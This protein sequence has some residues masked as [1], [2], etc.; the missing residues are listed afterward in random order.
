MSYVFDYLQGRGAVFT[1]IPHPDAE[2][3]AGAHALPFS[4]EEVVKTVVVMADFGPALMVVPASRRLDLELAGEATADP[5]VRPATE[6]ELEHA[7]PDYQIGA[8]PPLSMLLLAPMFVDPAVAERETIVF[9]AGRQ[10]VS[11]RMATRDLFGTDPVV[12]TPLTADTR[13]TPVP[14][15]EG[16]AGRLTSDGAS[17]VDLP[18]IA[19]RLASLQTS[20]DPARPTP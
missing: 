11:I 6:R 20:R 3:A 13:V 16:S 17:V 10:D 18:S 2:T 15:A 19:A 5:A 7:F 14:D 1:V 8:L 12:I 9:A 4:E